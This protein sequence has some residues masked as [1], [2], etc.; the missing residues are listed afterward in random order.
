MTVM[1]RMTIIMRRKSEPMTSVKI[2]AGALAVLGLSAGISAAH[3]VLETPATEVGKPYKA[4]FKVTHGCKGSPTVKVII[5]FPEGVIAVKPMPKAGW[6][7]TT[8]K[9]PYA[10]EYKF[11]HGL[12][13]KEGVKRIVWSGGSLP[14]DFYDEF[15]ASAFIAG[16]LAADQELAFTVTQ[17]CEQGEMRWGETAEP[18]HRDHLEYPAPLL[19]LLPAP[20]GEHH[21]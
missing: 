11:Y 13:L 15:V 3:V 2:L 10:K 5:E 16:E 9:A 14:D 20:K 17:Q 1:L 12:V 21:H 7:I 6:Q 8:E 19:K 18:E 4:V